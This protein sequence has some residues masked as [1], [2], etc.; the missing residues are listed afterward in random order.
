MGRREKSVQA[1]KNTVN[2]LIRMRETSFTNFL[3]C[4]T[5]GSLHKFVVIVMIFFYAPARGKFF[6]V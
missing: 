1:E 3:R 5:L 4:W 6:P 2:S